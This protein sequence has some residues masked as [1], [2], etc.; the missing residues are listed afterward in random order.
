MQAGS[1]VP[2]VV[3]SKGQVASMNVLV[4]T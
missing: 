4:I 1:Y 3:D 2:V